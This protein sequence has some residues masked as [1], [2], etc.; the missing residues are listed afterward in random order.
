MKRNTGLHN[1]ALAG[2]LIVGLASTALAAEQSGC[3]TCHLDEAM[4]VKNLS[5]AK[6]KVSTMQSGSG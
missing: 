5:V 1:A 6:P 3:V 4:I 2:L